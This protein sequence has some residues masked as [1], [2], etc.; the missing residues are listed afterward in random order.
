MSTYPQLYWY[1]PEDDFFLFAKGS[2]QESSWK[3]SFR[4]F[5]DKERKTSLWDPF[6]KNYSFF[7]AE[8]STTKMDMP[9]LQDNYAIQ[10]HNPEYSL[11]ENHVNSALDCI[12]QNLLQ[13][14]VLARM[15]KAHGSYYFGKAPEKGISFALLWDDDHIF[16]GTTPETLFKRKGS[17]L[18]TEAVAGTRSIYAKPEELLESKKDLHEFLFVRDTIVEKLRSVSKRIIFDEKPKIKKTATLQHLWSSIEV[19]LLDNI[20]DEILLDLLHPTPAVAGVPEI[21]AKNFIYEKESFDRG[22]YAAPIGISLGDFSH[23]IV[24][25]RSALIKEKKVHLF[26]GTGIVALSHSELEWEELNGKINRSLQ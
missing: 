13:K 1:N 18:F 5:L 7:P 25:I 17:I 9:I 23:Y 24:A 4:D 16:L 8:I 22:L 2:S 14:V 19:H 12:D 20:S 3:I 15:T 6:P 10:M 26:A 11:W 21:A